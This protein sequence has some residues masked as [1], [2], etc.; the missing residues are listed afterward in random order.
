M[1]L[2]KTLMI[3]ALFCCLA[4]VPGF[5][6]SERFFVPDV[7]YVKMKDDAGYTVQRKQLVHTKKEQTAV[8][9]EL[10]TLGYWNRAHETSDARL[11]QLRRNAIQNLKK[12]LPDMR[13]EFRFVVSDPKNRD[14]AQAL[15]YRLKDV[16]TVLRVPLPVKLPVPSDY[17]NLQRYDKSAA[18]GINADSVRIVYQ[19][20]GAGI[21]FCDVEY[22][23]HPAHGDLPA[24]T[25]IGDTPVDPFGGDGDHGTA[26]LGEVVSKDN[27]W[28]TTG[29]APDCKTYF[30]AA[31]TAQGYNVGAA[32][33][34]ALDTLMAGDVLLLEQQIAGPNVDTVTPET[35]RGLVPVEWYKPNYNAIQLAAGNGIIVIEAAGNGDEDLDDPVY[36]TGNNG[37]YPFLP[38][39]NSGAIM[40]G[41]GGVGGA[42]ST[43]SRLYFSNY[44]S[45][46]DVQGNGEGVTTTGYG[47]LYNTEGLDYYYTAQFGGTSSASPIVAGAAILLQS[48]YKSLNSG[49]ILSPEQV[50]TLLK[51]TGKAQLSGTAP[52]SQHIGPLPNV[53]AAIKKAL[54]NTTALPDPYTTAEAAIYPN[55]GQ[56][57]YNLVYP[58]G[59]PADMAIQVYNVAG[60]MLRSYTPAKGKTTIAI[61][62]TGQPAGIYLVRM[63][64]PV[65]TSVQRIVLEH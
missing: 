56:G 57:N 51:V 64:S 27:G 1:L 23:F 8:L 54:E 49:A 20:K 58:G 2:M 43:R 28:G 26:V 13:M 29:I 30:S 42:A 53:F 34:N 22:A 62:I 47:D 24:I 11:E 59:T 61:D 10:E 52:V 63:V 3:T 12:Q 48:T 36:S 7:L 46:L 17:T 4:L 14:K 41:A 65:Y 60:S 31:F 21:R 40:V 55:P 45:R 15:L 38:A 44:G 35:Q 5:S 16:E 25:I 39:N 50:R 33:T 37:H 6:Q 32:I 19:N 9:R 18:T